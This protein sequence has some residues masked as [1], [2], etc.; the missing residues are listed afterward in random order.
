[1]SASSVNKLD[2]FKPSSS[3][4]VGS[5][6]RLETEDGRLSDADVMRTENLQIK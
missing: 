2:G 6:R 4:C 1:M 3:A 5:S